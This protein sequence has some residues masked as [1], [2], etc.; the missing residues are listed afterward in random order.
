M[1]LFS[2]GGVLG[3]VGGALGINSNEQEKAIRRA[4]KSVERQ[5]QLGI[6]GLEG[7]LES[8]LGEL[9]PF[10][11]AGL[12]ALPSLEAGATL[13]GF[14]GN[15][16]DIF[17]SGVLDPLVAERMRGAESAF[18]KAGLTRSGGA[19][20]AAADIPTELAFGIEQLLSGRQG[21]LVGLGQNAAT[22][23]ANIR[24][25]SAANIA[26]LRAG[27]GEAQASS[28]LGQQQARDAADSNLVRLISGGLSGAGS[29]GAFAGMGKTGAILGALSD[30]RLKTD[31]KP[32][33][34]VGG[35]V[36]CE[37]NWVDGVEDLLK[38]HEM[39]LMNVGFIAQDVEEKYPQY[40]GEFN[41]FK[42]VDYIG[43]IEELEKEVH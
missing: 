29:A 25:T 33:G 5:A 6:E 11:T 2:G 43:L 35:L 12:G 10:A 19:I 21:N 30:I 4:G 34:E 15:I 38:D 37:W 24:G 13:P 31:I 14:A 41:G 40:S 32:L 26:N 3:K 27:V 1:G 23:L 39:P 20:R 8:T 18:G 22:N 28:L 17:S 42:T 36:L 9:Q 16:D 7:A